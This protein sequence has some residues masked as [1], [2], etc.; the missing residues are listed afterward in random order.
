M[1]AAAAEILQNAAAGVF[2]AA[3]SVMASA[4]ASHR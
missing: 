2:D 1:G 3:M 4:D